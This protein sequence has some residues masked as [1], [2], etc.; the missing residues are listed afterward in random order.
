MI[1]ISIC[2]MVLLR[3]CSQARSWP[4]RAC[5]SFWLLALQF[6]YQRRCWPFRWCFHS[7]FFFFQRRCWPFFHALL[8]TAGFWRRCRRRICSIFFVSLCSELCLFAS[9]KLGMSVVAVPCGN[10]PTRKP[11]GPVS[12]GT[13]ASTPCT[14]QVRV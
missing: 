8:A 11:S 5:Y 12:I 13:V 9:T 6:F 10:L 4:Q 1:R 14:A 2:V 3:T 7:F